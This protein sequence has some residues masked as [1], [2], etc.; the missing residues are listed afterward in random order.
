MYKEKSLVRAQTSALPG[1]NHCLPPPHSVSRA[2]LSVVT[3]L[4]LGCLYG[5]SSIY[6]SETVARRCSREARL[7]KLPITE[8]HT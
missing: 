1:H 4:V 5:K 3:R 2:A 6:R 7:L 8:L